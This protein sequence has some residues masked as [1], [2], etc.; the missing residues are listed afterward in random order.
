VLSLLTL[1]IASQDAKKL[2][3]TSAGVTA[4]T[5]KSAAVQ[6]LGPPSLLAKSWTASNQPDNL[7]QWLFDFSFLIVGAIVCVIGM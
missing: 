5:S 2:A 4:E 1:S 3:K 7:Y 6:L